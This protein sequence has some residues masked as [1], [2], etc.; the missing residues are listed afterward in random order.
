MIPKKL[1]KKKRGTL[2]EGGGGRPNT[3]IPYEKMA[4]TELPFSRGV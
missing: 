3:A 1:K 4:N 2:E